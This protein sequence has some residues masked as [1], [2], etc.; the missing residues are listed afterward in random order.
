MG[1]LIIYLLHALLSLE[2]VGALWQAQIGVEHQS[3]LHR[4]R[5]QMEIK[6]LH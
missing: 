5:W 2:R 1:N 6:L 3:L 4:Q